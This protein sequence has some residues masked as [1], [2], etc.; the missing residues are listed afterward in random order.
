[1]A[2]PEFEA[3]YAEKGPDA[4]GTGKFLPIEEGPKLVGSDEQILAGI[5]PVVGRPLTFTARDVIRPESFRELELIPFFR[6]HDVRYIIYWPIA[7][8]AE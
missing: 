3:F 1:V 8:A 7:K 2:D 5:K 4:F 6:N